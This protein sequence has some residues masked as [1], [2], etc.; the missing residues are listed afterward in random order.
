MA[1]GQ[2]C[3]GGTGG[4]DVHPAFN[5]DAERLRGVSDFVENRF[6]PRL[7]ALATCDTPG[8]CRDPV[9]DRMSYVDTHL[10][11]FANHGFCARSPNDP[12]FD[13]ECFLEN[14]ES[15]RKQSGGG[16]QRSAALQSARPRFPALCAARALDPHRQ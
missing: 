14:G 6:L 15:L 1:N 5:V 9:K 2:V 11:E 4:F 16:R 12:P 3:S 7:R 8:A 10:A 13:R